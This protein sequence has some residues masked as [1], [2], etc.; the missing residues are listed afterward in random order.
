MIFGSV[1]MS[2][3]GTSY[4][5]HSLNSPHRLMYTQVF[6]S[7]KGSRRFIREHGRSNGTN[8]SPEFSLNDSGASS[9]NSAEQL[10]LNGGTSD[11]LLVCRNSNTTLPL[12]VPVLKTTRSLL[13]G[14]SGFVGEQSFSSGSSDNQ[15]NAP[16]FLGRWVGFVVF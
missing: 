12:D 16:H 2:Y 13:N 5:I 10:S 11:A 7:P 6:P 9:F 3:R 14:D 15:S 1:A 4:K 8:R